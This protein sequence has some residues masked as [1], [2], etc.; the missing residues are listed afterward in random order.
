M[1][2]LVPAVVGLMLL[3]ACPAPDNAFLPCN[4]DADCSHFDSCIDGA[5]APTPAP[6]AGFVDAGFID[7]GFV[8]A[9]FVDAGAPADDA[10]FVD[11]GAAGEGEGEGFDGLEHEPN[12]TPD[13]ANALP[14]FDTDPVIVHASFQDS[15]DQDFFRIDLPEGNPRAF[16]HTLDADG[17][18]S[19]CPDT[20]LQLFDASG[21][22]RLARNDDGYPDDCSALPL[23]QLDAG[24]YVVE[25][26]TFGGH[27]DYEL[28]IED[29]SAGCGDGAVEDLEL[30]DDG[31]SDD[32]D[33]CS[34]ACSLEDG[35][36]FEHE[37]NNHIVNA[38]GLDLGIG[39]GTIDPAG[40]VDIWQM[41]LFDDATNVTIRT[42]GG[43]ND[44]CDLDTFV[45]LDD[46]SG[47]PIGSD[48][49]SGGGSGCSLLVIE[50]LA[51][52]TYFV[53]V[54]GTGTGAYRVV[55]STD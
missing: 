2:A 24:E 9:G 3:S 42:H 39:H 55:T 7:A 20:L 33:G 35:N 37:P 27:T 23:D 17:L 12:D 5:C 48:D 22:V 30:C 10:G 1:R 25:V 34:S 51:A 18:V 28:A 52:G 32:G 40:D 31:N 11:A 29:D 53:R 44:D 54:D 41:R 6:D 21:T 4:S 49:D 15:S 8:D 45:E 14:A 47:D 46:N 36:A 19:T 13:Q 38:S 50:S 16:V 43:F 26:T